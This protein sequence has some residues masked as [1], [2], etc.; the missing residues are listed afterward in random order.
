MEIELSGSLDL[1]AGPAA[2]YEWPDLGDAVATNS[3][4]LTLG[5]SGL[6]AFG[7]HPDEVRRRLTPPP[8]HPAVMHTA[9]GIVSVSII[10]SGRLPR[11]ALALVLLTTS[12]NEPRAIVTH[13]RASLSLQMVEAQQESMRILAG[14]VQQVEYVLTQQSDLKQSIAEQLHWIQRLENLPPES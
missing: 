8:A 11:P 7:L 14:V 10:P 1:L 12:E 2:L 6:E 5:S 3:P 9:K 4:M 13:L